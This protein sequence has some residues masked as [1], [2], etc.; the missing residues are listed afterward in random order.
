MQCSSAALCGHQA[1]QLLRRQQRAAARPAR[2]SFAVQAAFVPPP[3]WPGRVPVPESLPL[4][5][6]PKVRNSTFGY[7]ALL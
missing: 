6:G 5:D 7:P 4:C 2:A 1:A 3:A